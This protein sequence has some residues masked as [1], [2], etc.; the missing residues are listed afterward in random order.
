[1]RPIVRNLRFDDDRVRV[2][3]LPDRVFQQAT[4]GQ[5][6]R[7]G[8]E[9]AIDARTRSKRDETHTRVQRQH[10]FRGGGTAPSEVERIA[11]KMN[12]NVSVGPRFELGLRVQPG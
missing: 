9:L 11:P 7:E 12:E 6:P 3:L 5:S 4:P 10:T 2:T 1:L 8:L